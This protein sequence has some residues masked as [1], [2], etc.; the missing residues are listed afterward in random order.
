[1][2]KAN[3]DA[4]LA[5]PA[6]RM[7]A[8]GLMCAAVTV[9]ACLDASAKYLQT[10]TGLPT[11]QLVWLRFLGQ[12]LLIVL[13]LGALD[14]PRLLRTV[15]PW[16]QGFRSLL[17]LGSTAFNFAALLYLRLDQAVTI[18]FLAPMVVALLAGPLLGEWV[19]WRRMLAIAV[20]FGGI[21]LVIRPGFADVHWAVALSF[22]C[23]LCY[24]LFMLSTRYLSAY[25]PP[26]VT[27]FLSLI[28]GA[29]LCAPLAIATWVWP[30]DA[31]TWAL[32]ALPGLLGA[33]GHYLFLLAYRLAPASTLAPFVYFQLLAVTL[34]GYTVFGDL[35]DVWTLAG[36]GIIILS[37]IYMVHRERVVRG[38]AV[39]RTSPG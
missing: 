12:F 25:D 14:I 24:A 27:L 4:A 22:G 13:L 17:M 8:I 37:G 30:K 34:I 26:D 15:K 5:R 23:M 11:Q 20:G 3:P 33:T 32:L 10:R 36:S 39:Q 9:F 19:G 1:M 7:K 31:A 35:P 6:S 21:L 29:V 38:E 28:A 16:H 18:Q 2:Q